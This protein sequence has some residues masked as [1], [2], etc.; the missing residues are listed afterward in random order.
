MK[1]A[2]VA[3]I[4]AATTA[5]E[6]MQSHA[7]KHHGEIRD[8]RPGA[9]GGVLARLVRNRWVLA[10]VALLAVSFCAF[11]ALLS[12]ADLSFAVPATALS[13]VLETV[14]AKYLLKERVSPRRGLG[15]ALVAVGVFLVAL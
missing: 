7:M 11:L 1:W 12:E 14:F 2:L 3:V 10:S 9:L 13:Y 5:A 4:A 8:F 6:L 15:A